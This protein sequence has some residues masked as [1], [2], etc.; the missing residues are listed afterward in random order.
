MT[1]VNTLNAVLAERKRITS[2]LRQLRSS[3]KTNSAQHALEEAEM[4]INNPNP[5]LDA[6][7]HCDEHCNH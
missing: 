6:E 7:H 3:A 5:V 1:D 4:R 2:I